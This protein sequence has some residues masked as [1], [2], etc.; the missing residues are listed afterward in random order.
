MKTLN[1]KPETV[2]KKWYLI[3]A[4]DQILG[5]MS[6][7]IATI[8]RGKHRPEFSPHWDFG[9]HVVVINAEKVKVTGDKLNQKIYFRHSAYPGGAKFTPLVK[10]LSEH[11]ERVILHAVKGMLPKNSLGRKLLGKLKVYRGNEH[12]HR[13]QK[14]I[15]LDLH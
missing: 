4:Q 12:P 15:A 8:L 10:M 9:D 14:P 13:A 7:R 6:V 1:P 11:P 2:E 3:D 5:R